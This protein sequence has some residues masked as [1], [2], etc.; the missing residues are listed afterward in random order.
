MDRKVDAVLVKV[1]G[2]ATVG[3]AHRVYV[4]LAGAPID[5][6]D[7]DIGLVLNADK[8]DRIDIKW[9]ADKELVITYGQMRIFHFSNFWSTAQIS[10]RA[11]VVG[12][13]LEY[14]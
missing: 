3:F 13:R 7:L 10:E 14:M 9:I 8:V 2:N 4:V 5:K 6:R 11:Y 1:S 12:I